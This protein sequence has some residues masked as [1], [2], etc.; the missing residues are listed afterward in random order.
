VKDSGSGPLNEFVEV[1]RQHEKLVFRT[2]LRML[3]NAAD[4]EDA[5]QE[6]FSRVAPQ[7]DRFEGEIAAYLAVV[8][9]RVCID[10]IRRR[11]R[12]AAAHQRLHETEVDPRSQA[13]DSATL[14]HLWRRLGHRDRILLAHV[15][16][17]YSY[18]EIAGRM[19][20]S[21]GA[22]R[23]ALARARRRAR[24]GAAA[25]GTWFAPHYLK[26]RF[27]HLR[28]GSPG[29]AYQQQAAAVLLTVFAAAVG[30]GATPASTGPPASSAS[31]ASPLQEP[32]V[33]VI[34]RDGALRMASGTTAA[35]SA[36]VA[37][38][39]TGTLWPS[40][41]PKDPWG[42][43]ITLHDGHQE[44]QLFTA[45]VASPAYKQDQTVF[46][47]GTGVCA[48]VYGCSV[49]YKST[50]GGHSWTQLPAVG[51]QAGP[52]LLPPTYPADPVI[53][54]GGRTLQR[55]DD[56]GKT[57]RVVAPDGMFASIDPTAIAGHARVLVGSGP[58]WLYSQAGDRLDPLP[59]P[60]VGV[61]FTTGDRTFGYDGA[62]YLLS[63]RSGGQTVSA[64]GESHY[65]CALSGACVASLGLPRSFVGAYVPSN[66]VAL[67]RTYLLEAG[68][69]VAMSEDGGLSFHVIVS[70]ASGIDWAFVRDDGG[71]ALAVGYGW[72]VYD[73]AAGLLV[74]G[75][76]VSTDAGRS[77][78]MFGAPYLNT[79]TLHSLTIL[80]DGRALA[81]LGAPDALGFGVR[82]SAT[83]GASWAPMC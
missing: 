57:F 25:I 19:R 64:T 83:G 17:G 47:Y 34:S 61:G 49:L 39:R 9:R 59:P 77:F 74:G 32:V 52:I 42:S 75:A 5:V 26:A 43:N 15:Y 22:V 8:A 11:A 23:L 35:T 7:L 60:K 28:L 62:H 3:G 45:T 69:T 63:A 51:Y 41:P 65:V 58:L 1:Y 21:V 53:F 54:A 10:E 72:N 36:A 16:A 24:A 13:E 4:A 78:A 71:S 27:S 20:M 14:A 50:D 6:T 56:G 29:D 73:A 81:S 66:R 12:R 67:D 30:L 40:G 76:R 18:E 37:S 44:S 82:C 70:G 55:S 38:A 31:A 79:A 2:C 33:N 48:M 80:P 68:S 46:A